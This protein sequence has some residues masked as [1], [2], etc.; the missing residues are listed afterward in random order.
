MVARNAIRRGDVSMPRLRA[1]LTYA[2][3]LATLC[4]VLVL[5]GGTAFAV[6][7]GDF[8][9]GKA[10]SASSKTSLSASIANKAL[11]ISNTSTDIGAT[12]LGLTT[13]NGHPPFSVN[14]G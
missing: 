13:A 5:S 12:A 1:K 8:L 9:L 14:S 7:G 11:Q 2:N 3:V 6:T 10:N 4:L